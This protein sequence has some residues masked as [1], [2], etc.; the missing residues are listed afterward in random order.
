MSEPVVTKL[1]LPAV[2]RAIQSSV[3]AIM[4]DKL[5]AI[6]EVVEAH[7][8]R[9]GFTK[10]EIE[11]RIGERQKP[12]GRVQGAI[13]IL[14]LYGV[15]SPRMDMMSEMSGGTSCEAFG[16]AFDAAISNPE[17]GAIVI[18]CDSPGGNVI[19][20]PELAAKIAAARGTKPV[21]AVASGLMASAAYWI[22]SAADEIIAS[23]SSWVG[24]IGAYM[25]HEDS[26]AMQEKAGLK[27]QVVSAGKYK[28]EGA[29]GQPYDEEAL[30]FLQEQ[31][32]AMYD[33]FVNAVAKGRDVKASVV[34]SEYGQGRVLLAKQAKSA[35]M[36][37]RIA[38]LDETIARLAGTKP[39]TGRARATL[40]MPGMV[41]STGTINHTHSFDSTGFTLNVAEVA[42]PLRLTDT[43]VDRVVAA[44]FAN[45]DAPSGDDALSEIDSP[46]PVA[47]PSP[48][49]DVAS[50][51][52]TMPDPTPAASLSAVE[53][54]AAERKRTSRIMALGK[55]ENLKDAEIQA[56]IESGKSEADVALALADSRAERLKANP[57]I[58]VGADRNADRKFD[59][60]GEQLQAI[61]NHAVNGK[62]HSSVDRRLYAAAASGAA[63]ASSGADGGFLIQRSSR[64]TSSSHP[65]RP[66]TFSVA[67]TRTKSAPNA[68]GLEVVYLDETSR[69]TGSRWGGVQV[70][71]GAEADSRDGR[72]SRR[73]ASGS[74]V[75]K[76]SSVSP[77]MTERL[78]QDASSISE[79]VRDGVHEEF[80]SRPRTRW[81]AARASAR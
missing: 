33:E 8:A 47:D 43:Q 16:R 71:R 42:P 61:Y 79:R 54:L 41:A 70:Y 74:A 3:W 32:D 64:S 27:Y 78:L 25:A 46:D 18:D 60:L 80:R 34:K 7:A 24:S 1:K 20:V 38:T 19:G 36:I 81:F 26:S 31:V 5:D 58:S 49:P 13:Q 63:V 21:V 6:L 76:T 77:Y 53:I 68:D 40:V 66:A 59:N 67:P 73:S 14:P 11:A 22:C 17:I 2:R 62:D 55:Q 30:A 15:I 51:E 35:G 48:R 4:P 28:A 37:D 45:N 44:V 50:Q 56:F 52:N 39:S 29:A 72:R 65:L 23:P 9:G 10:E 75:S 69:A 12:A 57:L